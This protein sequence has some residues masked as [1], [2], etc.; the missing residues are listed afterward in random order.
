MLESPAYL[1]L[2]QVSTTAGSFLMRIGS[3]ANAAPD[4]WLTRN[5]NPTVPGDLADSAL[6]AAGWQQ[7][8]AQFDAGVTRQHRH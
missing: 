8:V 7:V 2:S 5:A 4:I 6:I 1:G 3:D